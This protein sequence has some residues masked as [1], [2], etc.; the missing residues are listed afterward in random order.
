M[1]WVTNINATGKT[2]KLPEENIKR[3]SPGHQDRKRFLKR[4]T[5]DYPH[6]RNTDSSDFIKIKSIYS[7]KGIIKKVNR[8]AIDWRNYL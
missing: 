7:I 8:Q 6:K 1:R 5:K 4:E 3:L 2:I